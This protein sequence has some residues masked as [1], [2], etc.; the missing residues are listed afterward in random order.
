MNGRGWR[1]RWLRCRRRRRWVSV[2]NAPTLAGVL[3]ARRRFSKDSWQAT[4]M[5]VSGTVFSPVVWISEYVALAHYI[6]RGR[7]GRADR[8]GRRQRSR[9]DRLER[10][11]PP[12]AARGAARS[13][14]S[15]TSGWR[16]RKRTRVGPRCAVPSRRWWARSHALRWAELPRSA[17]ARAGSLATPGDVAQLARAPALQAGGRGFESHR[18]HDRHSGRDL[19]CPSRFAVVAVSPRWQGDASLSNSHVVGRLRLPR[20]DRMSQSES[21]AARWAVRGLRAGRLHGPV[22]RDDHAGARCR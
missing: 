16:W 12:V 5:G 6:G 4:V 8:G 1:S 13:P 3:F 21:Q 14:G 10:T 18:L 19:A 17:G 11:I 2:A 9:R 15:A 22:G 20:L 7:A